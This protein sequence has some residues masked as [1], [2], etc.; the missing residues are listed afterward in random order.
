[1]TSTGA[2]EPIPREGPSSATRA[3]LIALAAASFVAF[4]A[5]LA[6]QPEL[7]AGSDKGA[8]ALSRSPVGFAGLVTLLKA[9]GAS[10]RLNRQTD[11]GA[12]V[13]PNALFVLTPTEATAPEAI[14][15]LARGRRVLLILPK[16]RT[17]PDPRR[18]GRLQQA[19]TAAPEAVLGQARAILAPRRGD[20]EVAL[21]TDDGPQASLVLSSRDPRALHGAGYRIGPVANLRTLSGS[22]TDPVATDARGRGIVVMA[23]QSVQQVV[24]DPDVLDNQ[25]VA[26]L[27]SAR[28]AVS[29]VEGLADGGP[30]VFDLTLPGLGGTRSLLKLAFAPPFLPATACA[31]VLATLAGMMAG[32]RFGAERRPGRA[33]AFGKRALADSAASLLAIAGREPRLAG[34]YSE[35]VRGDVIDGMGL[36]PGLDRAAQDAMLDRIS[37]DRGTAAWSRISTEAATVKTRAQLMAFAKAADSWRVE[38]IRGRG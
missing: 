10:V 2:N 22:A 15:R 7:S 1:M 19:G 9:D 27:A 24:A 6:Y 30:I 5:A 34:R 3:W 12:G 37:L 4:L 21:A 33:Y 18:P 31:L 23:A 35:A 36:P 38:M 28:A 13:D 17:A 26:N 14:Q 29:L 25:G 11:P 20:G 8:H 16:W 32:E